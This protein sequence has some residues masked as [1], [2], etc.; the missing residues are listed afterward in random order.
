[1]AK[2]IEYLKAILERTL[3]GRVEVVA[4]PSIEGYRAYELDRDR[5]EWVAES[6]SD[7]DGI[8]FVLKTEQVSMTITIPITDEWLACFEGEDE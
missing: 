2:D 4:D 8:T 1:M 5:C 7:D 3:Q 6:G